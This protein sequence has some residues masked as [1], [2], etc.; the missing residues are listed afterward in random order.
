[1]GFKDNL[2]KNI[3]YFALIGSLFFYSSG[4]KN[5]NKG[6]SDYVPATVTREMG[7]IPDDPYGNVKYS[8]IPYVLKIKTKNNEKYTLSL[9]GNGFGGNSLEYLED[10]IEKGTKIKVSKKS[11]ESR[12]VGNDQ[13]GFI[14][15]S[16]VKLD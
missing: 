14:H 1:M 5:K 16:K 12:Q 13:I 10:K 11:L 3:S 2:V 15:T 4:C 6:N 9:Y 8:N 7:R